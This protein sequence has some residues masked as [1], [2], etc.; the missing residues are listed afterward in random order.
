MVPF[1]RLI[2]FERWHAVNLIDPFS[3]T[4]CSMR[5][6]QFVNVCLAV[7]GHCA[8]WTSLDRMLCNQ[9]WLH[10]S[11]LVMCT[12]CY[13]VTCETRMVCKDTYSI[14]LSRW[15]DGLTH[16]HWQIQ[17]KRPQCHSCCTVLVYCSLLSCF[18]SLSLLPPFPYPTC[19]VACWT[20]S[21]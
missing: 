8:N 12:Y 17:L 11:N 14:E 21:S 13:S 19:R 10:C 16:V 2:D 5:V 15:E 9:Q 3:K 7:T 20:K 6:Y 18:P 4:T 1:F